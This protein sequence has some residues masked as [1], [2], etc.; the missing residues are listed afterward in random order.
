MHI[1][2]CV[3]EC[4]VCMRGC[5]CM[6]VSI[7]PDWITKAFM[8]EP[9]PQ[10]LVAIVLLELC[11]ELFS[12]LSGVFF[13]L[14]CFCPCVVHSSW[15]VGSLLCGNIL[16]AFFLTSTAFCLPL[17]YFCCLEVTLH[18]KLRVYTSLWFFSCFLNSSYF[19]TEFCWVCRVIWIY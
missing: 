8:T 13:C 10:P 16:S 18:T 12:P 5:E 3:H 4:V 9:S 11:E 17:L 14:S 6:F 2:A 1:C 19:L 7:E 15:L